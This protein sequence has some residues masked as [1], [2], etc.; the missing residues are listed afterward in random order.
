MAMTITNLTN[1]TPDQREELAGNALF[2]QYI[3]T[4]VLNKAISQWDPSSSNGNANSLAQG[5]IMGTI[6]DWGQVFAHTVAYYQGTPL[7]WFTLTTDFTSITGAALDA[8]VAAVWDPIMGT[9]LY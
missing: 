6:A 7:A 2:Q 8:I 5:V 3:M 9:T 4:A 1:P